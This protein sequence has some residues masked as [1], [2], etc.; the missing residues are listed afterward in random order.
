MTSGSL[1]IFIL[2]ILYYTFEAVKCRLTGYMS[3]FVLYYGNC[4]QSIKPAIALSELLYTRVFI[5]W[6]C[7]KEMYLFNV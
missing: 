4:C 1:V 7:A 3:L 2:Y 6:K 5:F